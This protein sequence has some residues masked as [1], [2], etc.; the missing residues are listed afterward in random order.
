MWST[1]FGSRRSRTTTARTK[2]GPAEAREWM[3]EDMRE[4][5]TLPVAGIGA[6]IVTV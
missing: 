4:T 6:S 3:Q 1:S 2:Y 5:L